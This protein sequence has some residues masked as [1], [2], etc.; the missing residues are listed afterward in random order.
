MAT[1]DLSGLDR[2]TERFRR[3]INPNAKPL[4][5]S[6]E[7]IIADDNQRGIMNRTD[8]HGYPMQPVT[9]RPI[10]PKKQQIKPQRRGASAFQNPG[11]GLPTS[12]EYRRMTGPPT[13]PRGLGSR[14]ITNLL[15]RSGQTAATTWQTV[16]YWDGVVDR[17]RQPFLRYLFLRWDLRGVRPDGIA[18]AGSAARAWMIDEIRSE[19][20]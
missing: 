9:Y 7:K 15:F 2:L 10:G 12:A 17:R 14:V 5:L 11:A 3:L 18:K 8:C 4:M 13:A 1:L 6:W 20:P 16:G 19:S